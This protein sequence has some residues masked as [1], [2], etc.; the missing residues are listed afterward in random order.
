MLPLD[1]SDWWGTAFVTLGLMIAAAGGIGGG[2]ILVPLFILVY[3][4]PPKNAIALSNF[5][6]VG[7]SITNIVLNLSK[8]HPN[9]DRPLI[10]WDLILVMEPL[11]MVGAIVGAFG[12][13]LLPDWLLTVMLVALLAFTTWTTL[14]K[15]ISQWQKESQQFEKEK[16][17]LLVQA[18]DAEVEL[19]EKAEATPLLQAD[20]EAD[21]ESAPSTSYA[22]NAPAPARKSPEEQEL[23]DLIDSERNTPVD[24]AVILTGMVVAVVVLNLLKGGGKA[25]PSPLGLECGGS[26]YW[27]IQGLVILVVLAVSWHMRNVLIEK[28]KLKKRLHYAYAVG[29][30]EWNE[31]NTIIYPAICFTAGLFAGMFGV[32]GGIVKGPLM[33]QMGVH[34]LVAS[35]TVAVMIM[36]TSV[37]GTAMYIAFGTLVLDYGLAL[38]VVGLLATAVG[39]FGV[40]YLVEKYRRV[41][42]VSFSIGA[43]VAL[44]TLLMGVQ[45]IFSLMSTTPEPKAHVCD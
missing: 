39:Q 12:S 43:V 36:F 45:S 41:S 15:G 32:G 6:I 10:D 24:K 31:R 38:F 16:K 33:L 3:G 7:S 37:A 44:S 19:V 21:E 34:P 4:F 42:L 5:T 30:V 14:E 28:W 20:K 2:G 9:V 18:T 22:S 1:A 26:G 23:A 13:K 17:S 40:S 35:N 27:A 11:T 8:R 25:F 29:D